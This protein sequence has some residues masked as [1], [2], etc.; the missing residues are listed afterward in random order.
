M[1]FVVLFTVKIS[2]SA[3]K[4]KKKQQQKTPFSITA[5]KK[6][7][8]KKILPSREKKKAFLQFIDFQINYKNKDTWQYRFG[9]VKAC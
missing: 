8:S 1:L 7:L 4:I 5:K 3:S 2:A 9:S 6:K